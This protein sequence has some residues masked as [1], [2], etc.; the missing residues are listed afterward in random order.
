MMAW[1]Y[2]RIYFE[3]D[4][5]AVFGIVYRPTF[6]NALRTHFRKDGHNS[7]NDPDPGWYALRNTVYAAGCRIIEMRNAGKGSR[8]NIMS[9]QSWKYFSNA[10]SVHSDLLYY[11]TS[12][13]AVQALAMMVCEGP[14]GFAVSFNSPLQ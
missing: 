5:D 12:L 14:Q 6:E 7:D 1:Q 3:M 9:N 11:R 8:T 13:M 4:P 10:L 2:C